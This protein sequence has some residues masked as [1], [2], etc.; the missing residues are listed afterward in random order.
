[1]ISLQ[2]RAM[3]ERIRIETGKSIKET[4]ESV[5]KAVRGDP[6]PYSKELKCPLCGSNRNRVTCKLG[7]VRYHKCDFCGNNFRTFEPKTEETPIENAVKLIAKQRKAVV[8]TQKKSHIKN[9]KS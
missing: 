7:L 4:F 6:F 1:M 9:R 5:I 8:K 2:I 3:A